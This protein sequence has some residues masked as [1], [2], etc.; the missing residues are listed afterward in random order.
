M[1]A[2][3]LTHFQIPQSRVGQRDNALGVHASY[4]LLSIS[5]EMSYIR[6]NVFWK[7]SR[8]E[9]GYCR[10]QHRLQLVRNNYR[11]N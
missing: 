8:I 1:C 6:Q 5:N 2:Q 11:T 7:Q 9:W 3:G 10:H 4:E